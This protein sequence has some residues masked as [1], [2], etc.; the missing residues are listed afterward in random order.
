MTAE[1]KIDLLLVEDECLHQLALKNVVVAEP[2][3]GLRITESSEDLAALLAESQPD[4]IVLNLDMQ[5]VCGICLLQEILKSTTDIPVLTYYR[6]PG[7][8][9]MPPFHTGTDRIVHLNNTE[10]LNLMR[11]FVHTM[12]SDTR[13]PS[14]AFNAYFSHGGLAFEDADINRL[15]PREM[16][17]YCLCGKGFGA[18]SISDLFRCSSRTVE[19]HIVRIQQK[20]RTGNSEALRRHAASYSRDNLCATF[21]RSENHLCPYREKPVSDCPCLH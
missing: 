15:S 7:A 8:R 16:D 18:K 12:M 10:V 5:L 13:L 17:V 14:L 2:G 1:G 3:I 20:L 11:E 21:S 9:K 4:V 19:T 6:E